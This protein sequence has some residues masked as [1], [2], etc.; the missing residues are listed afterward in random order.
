[1]DTAG[2]EPVRHLQRRQPLWTPSI[3]DLLD[4]ESSPIHESHSATS[5][6]GSNGHLR[7]KL[8]QAQETKPLVRRIS[9][10]ARTQVER[11]A[12][13]GARKQRRGS[14]DDEQRAVRLKGEGEALLS[15]S[16]SNHQRSNED[17]K[18]KQQ[19]AGRVTS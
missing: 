8:A 12:Y 14:S 16:R 9:S 3:Y 19:L 4:R 13:R 15:K 2:N 7:S 17:L 18:K 1:M 6:C 5:S 10:A 11:Q